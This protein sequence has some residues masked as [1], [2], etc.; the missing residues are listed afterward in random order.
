MSKKQENSPQ[1]ALSLNKTP[2]GWVVTEFQIQNGE[3]VKE[4]KSQPD[5]RAIALEKLS[6]DMAAIFW[7]NG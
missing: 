5:L 4:T 3:I 2:L 7:T 6:R 1:I